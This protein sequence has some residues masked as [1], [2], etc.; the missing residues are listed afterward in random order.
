MS[1]VCGAIEAGGTKFICLVGSGPDDIRAQARI[2]TTNPDETLS[3]VVE[4][5]QQN[6]AGMQ[7]LGVAAFGPLDLNE[8]SSTYGYIT[9]TPKPK[10]SNTDLL[11]PLQAAFDIPVAFD[12]DVNGAALGEWCWGAARGLDDFIYLTVGTG[13][14]GGA[15]VN[16]QLLHGSQHP[17]MGHMLLPHDRQQDP[18]DGICPFHGDCLEGLAN[19]PAI[20]ARWGIPAHELS[21]DHPAWELEAHYLAIA[22]MNLSLALSPQRIILGGGVMQQEHLFPLIRQELSLLLSGYLQ[23]DLTLNDID[24][25]I[26]PPEFGKQAGILGALALGQQVIQR[27]L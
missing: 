25:Y 23:T 11:S 14:G 2:P 17:E 26:V 4:F 10:W 1:A 22:C 8:A 20:Q 21:A 13:I 3:T 12:T 9:A 19:G 7:A 27:A 24:N 15:M 18:F 16:G 6:G 5:F